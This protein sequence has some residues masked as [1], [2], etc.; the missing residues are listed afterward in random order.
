MQQGAQVFH[1]DV[2]MGNR[3]HAGDGLQLQPSTIVEGN[4]TTLKG[5]HRLRAV[6][7]NL[8]QVVEP[9]GGSNLGADM[10]QSFENLQLALG[11]HE[12]GVFERAAHR[13]RHAVH[14]E[15]VV[16]GEARATRL[17]DRFEHA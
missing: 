12:A 9:K 6:D 3:G 11:M 10:H 17:V 5:Q 8:Q 16:V 7:N 2:A 13:F 15:Q 4:R 1:L 14:E